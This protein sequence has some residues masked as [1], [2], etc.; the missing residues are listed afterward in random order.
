[1]GQKETAMTEAPMTGTQQ[2]APRAAEATRLTG[3]V[4]ITLPVAV[5]YDLG[6]LQKGIAALA[7]RLGC[8][9]C[10]SG[11]NCTFQVERDLVVNERLQISPAARVFA[12]DPDGDPVAPGLVTTVHLAREVAFDLERVQGAVAKI[13]DRLGHRACFSGFDVAFRQELDLMTVDRDLN[14]QDFGS[15]L[16]G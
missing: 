15:R 7:Q 16:A 13:V 6:A 8:A 4:R 5:A 2:S 11:V 9:P 10:V 14:V 12:S 3:P 1:M